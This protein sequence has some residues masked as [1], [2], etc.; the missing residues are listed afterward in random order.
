MN[1]K[2]IYIVAILFS[3]MT[4]FGKANVTS[5][6]VI[7]LNP[8]GIDIYNGGCTNNDP[9]LAMTDN[10]FNTFCQSNE[11][12]L[13]SFNFDFS[14]IPQNAV[15]NSLFAN[16]LVHDPFICKTDNEIQVT[17]NRIVEGESIGDLGGSIGLHTVLQTFDRNATYGFIIN[18]N[19]CG[20]ANRVFEYSL[21]IEYSFNTPAGAN[22]AVVPINEVMLTFSEVIM[23]GQTTATQSLSGSSP[24]TGFKLGNP[25]TYYSISTTAQFNPSVEVCISYDE[26]QFKNEKN[27]KLFHFENGAWVNV[28]TSVDTINN[29]ICG[30]VS[31]FSEFG[32]FE[33]IS[34]DYI[35]D[36]VQSFN[37]DPDI[38]QGLLDKLSAAKSANERNQN[39]TARNILK[40]FINLVNAQE[41]K[42]ITTNQANI[43]RTDAQALIQSLGGNLL[44]TIFKWVLFGWLDGFIN[45]MLSTKL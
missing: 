4:I 13:T 11:G 20:S 21:T 41:N 8:V 42:K 25:P 2:K 24:P 6:E 14:Q 16:L 31:S 15:I 28:T 3:A 19:G 29:E 5:A 9:V 10:S 39:K 22:I 38:E 37:L 35:I 32:L 30:S 34:I 44:S 18:A 12:A 45:A 23:A 36:E 27:L 7:T 33:D 1:M 40:A 26:T 43:L 17:K